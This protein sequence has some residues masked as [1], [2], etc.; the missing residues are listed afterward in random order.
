MR[1]QNEPIFLE[2]SYLK[3]V[4]LFA[5]GFLSFMS[6]ILTP[7]RALAE[8][9][10]GLVLVNSASVDYDG[11]QHYIQPYLDNFGV[12]YTVLD[13]A[14][15]SIGSDVA[16][17]AVI[18]VGH[19]QLD[20]DGLYLDTTEE[21]Y[22][23]AAVSAGTG[24]VNFD[25]NLSDGSTPY[26]QYVDD[27]FGFS[28]MSPPTGS[29]I[30]FISDGSTSIRINCWEDD[31]Q[32]PVLTTTENTTD[33]V[34]NDGQ[35]TEFLYTPSRD[36][37]SILAGADEEDHGLPV[38]RFYASGI[39]NGDYEILANLYTSSSGRDMRY[40]YGFNPGEPKAHYVDTVGGAG[41]SDQH[42]EYSLGTISIT[43]GTINIYV[44][45]ADLLA[46]TYAFF[47]WAWIRLVEVGAP[48]DDMHYITDRHEAGE[49]IGTGSM[50]LAGI[51]LPEDVTSIATS[52]SQPFLAVTTSGGGRAVQWG[53]YDWMSNAVKGPVYGLDDLVW[54]SI[55]WAARKPFVMQCMPPFVTMRVDDES[56]PFDW[57]HV[58]NDFGF[59]P[60]TGLFFHNIDT[61][62]PKY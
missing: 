34:E 41:G 43:D 51:T 18:I 29:G 4:I 59:K 1:T 57:I 54:R 10:D 9:T 42:E 55:V 17:Y 3:L 58:A 32:D 20:P 12:P 21:D 61:F 33:L 19:R 23:S 52:S 11:F 15:E 13:I 28:Y 6:F 40:Y 5:I 53:T 24:L 7:Q 8:R 62:L 48:P 16:N 2:K 44:Q 45:D 60:W 38:L 35:W 30:T 46:G 37:P 26:Y 49:F 25:N 36:Y 39:P 56:G 14:T 27:I 22:I 47:G 31:H 50:T